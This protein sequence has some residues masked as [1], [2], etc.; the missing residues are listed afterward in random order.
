[1]QQALIENLDFVDFSIDDLYLLFERFD[2]NKVGYLAFNDFKRVIL[3]FSREYASLVS[4]RPDIYNRNH[5]LERSTFF[6]QE[7]F[8]KSTK[9]QSYTP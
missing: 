7:T 1:M 6:N 9:I 5:P 2:R 3:P 8:V 4:D